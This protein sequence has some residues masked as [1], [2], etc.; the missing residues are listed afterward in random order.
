MNAANV[1]DSSAVVLQRVR[2]KAVFLIVIR[3]RLFGTA[4]SQGSPK[5]GPE[6]FSRHCREFFPKTGSP[7][8]PGG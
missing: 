6:S 4:K 3:A 5:T 7:R 8:S 1:V 2:L